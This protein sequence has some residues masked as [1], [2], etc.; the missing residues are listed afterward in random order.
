MQETS[1]TDA[2]PKNFDILNL[3]NQIH[4][5]DSLLRSWQ[6]LNKLRYSTRVL[7]HENL[8]RSKESPNGLW[9]EP[10]LSSLV[11]SCFYDINFNILAPTSGTSFSFK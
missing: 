6:S 11:P 2:Y 3:L 8:S 9:A 5:A 10:G 1:N 7:D 4:G